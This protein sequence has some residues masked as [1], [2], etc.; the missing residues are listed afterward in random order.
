MR[1]AIM[2]EAVDILHEKYIRISS[3]YHS[4]YESQAITTSECTSDAFGRYFE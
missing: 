2:E 3:P 4:Q 1:V